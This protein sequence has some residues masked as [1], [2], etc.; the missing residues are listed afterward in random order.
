MTATTAW[1]SAVGNG[2]GLHPPFVLADKFWV[3]PAIMVVIVWKYFGF[4][5]MIYI[6]GLQSIPQR[7]DR[8]GAARRRQARPDH[9][10]HQDPDDLVVDRGVDVLR[11]R[12]RAAAVRRHHSADQW[13][14]QQLDPHH[15][16]LPLPVR[17][18]AAADTAS[19]APSAS[20]CSS[21]ASASPSSTG[22]H[23]FRARTKRER[24]ARAASAA[25]PSV[26][27]FQWFTLIL[28]ALFTLVPLYT[29]IVGGFK[30]RGRAAGQPV[31]PAGEL[32]RRPISSRSSAA[33]PSSRRCG[34]RW[35]SRCRRW[36]CRSCSPR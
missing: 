8:G 1:C 18:P 31:R 7:G 5:M 33:R 36:C 26:S 4:H 9:P 34:T 2:L 19:A 28:V 35:S 13:R 27:P 16:H 14:A 10:P 29:T 32:G 22:A 3:L 15:R 6:A 24:R 20:S 12:R 23:C 11:H 25:A 17:R 21:C 30:E